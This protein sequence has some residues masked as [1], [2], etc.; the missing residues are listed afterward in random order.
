MSSYKVQGKIR[1]KPS[2]LRRQGKMTKAQKRYFREFWSEYG[3]DLLHG[4]QFSATEYFGNEQP[5]TLEIG[6]GQ[7]E[8]L[9]HRAQSEPERNFIGIEVHKPAIAN[10]LNQL[11]QRNLN[12]VLLL[13][14]DAL[15]VCVDHLR[16]SLL[17]EICIFYP[18][19]WEDAERRIL[20]AQS[21]RFLQ[22]HCRSGTDLY[23]TTD[24][25]DYAFFALRE[26]SSCV[27]WENQ[28]SSSGFS[29]RPRWRQVSKY[30]K[31]AISEGR[32]SFDLHFRF[33]EY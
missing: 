2:F 16:D 30:E 25:E 24:V 26:F 32:D 29:I 3:L 27:G 21:I 23:C 9:L 12:N 15:L 6:F 8:T 31:K 10:C 11:K 28:S 14:K 13:K 17:D 19:P 1:F 4:V 20:R 5:V 22:K 33:Q 7:A 18:K